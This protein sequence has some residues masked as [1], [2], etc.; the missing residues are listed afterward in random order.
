MSEATN[1]KYVLGI[2]GSARRGGNTEILVDEALRG[3]E[4]AGAL[5][6]KVILSKLDIGPCRGCDGCQKTGQC[7]QKD[8]MPALLE[9]MQ[10][11][12]VWV[13]GTPVYWWGPTA[14]FKAFL[15]RWYG[16]RQVVTFK[17][18]RIILTIPLEDTDPGSPRHI[19]GMFQD[20]LDYL[21]MELFATV[22]APGVF[23]RGAVREHLDILALA[24]RAGREAIANENK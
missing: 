22:L 13:L 12:Q 18:R 21:D 10:R 14:Q 23:A 6:E 16:A 4:E 9:K 2:V 20:I 15:D 11:S 8:D 17:G 1:H 19:V 24:H 7:V 5:T 3:A